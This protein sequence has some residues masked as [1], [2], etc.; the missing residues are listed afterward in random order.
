MNDGWIKLDR[1]IQDNWLWEDKPFDKGKAW[2]DLLM[3]ANWKDN[4]I[5][6][7]GEI[8]TCKRGD[9][10]ISITALAERWG[11]SRNRVRSF[12]LLLQHDNMVSTNVT[13]HRTTITIENYDKY[14]F[15]TSTKISTSVT[16]KG[17]Q[18]LQQKG[19][20]GYNKGDTTNKDNKLNKEK[21]VKNTYTTRECCEGIPDELMDSH[22]AFVEAMKKRG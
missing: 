22:N 19:S 16:T 18:G 10:N 2:I 14:Q 13:T 1:A 5:P 7:K 3:L 17:Q 6:F 20:K 21:K 9:V 15:D 8:V 12:L 4:K 11:W